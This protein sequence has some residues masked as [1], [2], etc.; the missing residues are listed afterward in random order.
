MPILYIVHDNKL[1]CDVGAFV[2]QHISAAY[3]LF[4]NHCISAAH[5]DFSL[6]S[7]VE[8]DFDTDDVFEVINVDRQLILDSSSFTKED[9]NDD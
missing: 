1:K 2:E 4:Y 3:T 6:F 8:F 5:S 9:S 7:F